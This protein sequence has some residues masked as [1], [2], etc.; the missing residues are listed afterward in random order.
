[1]DSKGDSASPGLTALQDLTWALVLTAGLSSALALLWSLPAFFW[2]IAGVLFIVLS[3]CVLRH[4]L[5]DSD[6]GPANRA[7][8]LRATLVIVLFASAPFAD[9][10]GQGVWLYGIL[11]L[12]AL[13][14][15]GVDGAIARATNS[16]TEFG[17]RFDMELDATFL[18]GLC[19]AVVAL[20]K[21]GLWV[22]ALGLMRYGF[23]I[24]GC[25]WR[26]LN[27]PLPESFRRKTICVWQIVSL[28]VAIL[29]PI[30][31]VFA[32]LALATAL[33]LLICSF[34]VDIYWLFQRRTAHATA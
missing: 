32:S 7:T 3:G 1:M 14:L 12:V 34:Y 31:P 5:P 4:W 21:A 16:Q 29:P 30:S 23:L 8:L 22:L 2:L 27:H 28:M 25:F 18:L 20:D 9:R 17:A 15:D 6:I 13:I 33:I 19:V 11:A 24:A 10:L 26:W